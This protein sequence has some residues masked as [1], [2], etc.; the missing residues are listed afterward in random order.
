MKKLLTLFLTLIIICLIDIYRPFEYKF[1]SGSIHDYIKGTQ[2][3]IKELLLPQFANVSNYKVEYDFVP[4]QNIDQGTMVKMMAEKGF[5]ATNSCSLVSSA[6]ALNFYLDDNK[7]SINDLFLECY[8]YAVSKGWYDSKSGT[9]TYYEQS[10]FSD[11][12]KL[13]GVNHTTWINKNKI[14]QGVYDFTK[15]KN[16]DSYGKVQLFGVKG[17]SMI[18]NGYLQVSFD[19]DKTNRFLWHTWTER[20]TSYHHYIICCNGWNNKIAY[21]GDSVDEI[22]AAYDYFPIGTIEEYVIGVDIPDRN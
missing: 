11:I 9:Y 20:V 7:E 22:D 4:C 12:L 16:G 3:S 10:I 5:T 19:Y 15:A 1:N 6:M 17:H 13:K 2:D 18:A 14:Y 8:M 21:K